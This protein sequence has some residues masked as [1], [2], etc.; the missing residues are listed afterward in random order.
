MAV[1]CW[2]LATLALETKKN[3]NPSHQY[4]VV[5][6]IS[7]SF[8]TQQLYIWQNRVNVNVITMPWEN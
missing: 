7:S 6:R 2:V 4:I 8:M 1:K 3:G 5:N